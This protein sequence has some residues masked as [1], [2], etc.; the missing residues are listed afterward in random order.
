MKMRDMES[1]QKET[2]RPSRML[3]S[4][5]EEETMAKEIDRQIE[6]LCSKN[7]DEAYQ[8]LKTLEEASEQTERVYPYMNR[9]VEMMDH[10]N[11]YV[12]SRG[13]LLIA[14][15]AKWDVDFKID[16]VFDDYLKHVTDAKPITARQCIKSLPTFAL[17]KPYLVEDIVIALEKADVSAYPD[18]MRSLI[19]QDI[20]K[21]LS[22]LRAGKG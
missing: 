15:N 6:L 11:S 2:A 8:A 17:H 20:R 14:S 19:D 16:E 12:R 5:H 10:A 9:F 22:E 7:N 18:S 13:L 4:D 1:K 21:A 3:D